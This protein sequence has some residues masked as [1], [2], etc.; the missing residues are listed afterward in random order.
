MQSACATLVSLVGVLA[1][2][3]ASAQFLIPFEGDGY[4]GSID[5]TPIPAETSFYIPT[6]GG[7]GGEL[8]TY[9]GNTLGFS[10]NPV[11]GEQFVGLQRRPGGYAR[12]QRDVPWTNNCWTIQFDMNLAYRGTLPATNHA[13]SVSIQPLPARGSAALIFVWDDTRSA[14]T[15]SVRAF[16]FDEVGELPSQ[17]GLLVDDSA[18]QHLLA[19]HWYR[20]SFRLELASNRLN[21]ISIRDLQAAPVRITFS[22]EEPTGYFLGEGSPLQAD[23]DEAALPTS[24]RFFAGGGF[25][26]DPSSGN[27]LAIDNL[28][29]L[30]LASDCNGDVDDDGDV[31]LTDLALLLRNFGTVGGMTHTDGDVICDGSVD[32]PDLALLLGNFGVVCP[33]DD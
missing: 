9:D 23:F 10:Q 1:V 27:T 29:V 6:A 26:F 18:F 30:A 15:Y 7:F 28:G 4:P 14:S 22:P 32:L 3:R 8:Y 31:D 16:G 11:G 33:G 13:A 24:V 25:E 20:I 17:S 2:P 19:D 12:M 21:S 5:G